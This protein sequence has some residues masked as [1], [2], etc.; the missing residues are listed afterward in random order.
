ML[1]IASGATLPAAN[2]VIVEAGGTLL[3]SGSGARSIAGSCTLADG[4]VLGFRFTQTGESPWFAFASAP[5]LKDNVYVNLGF[6]TPI[7]PRSLGGKMLLAT[8]VGDLNVGKLGFDDDIA[9]KPTWVADV[10]HPFVVED[11]N[12][13]LKVKKPGLSITVR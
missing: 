2:A 4:A 1:E 5:T 3:A 9:P 12:L 10:D 11:G 8:G 6:T 7:A 13:Y